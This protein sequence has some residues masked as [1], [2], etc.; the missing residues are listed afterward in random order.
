[1]L[2]DPRSEAMVNNF[3]GQWLQAR[4]MDTINIEART[5]LARDN[6]TEKELKQQIADALAGRG[7]RQGFNRPRPTNSVAGTNALGQ[8][9]LLAQARP[10][11]RGINLNNVGAGVFGKSDYDLSPEVRQ[12]MERETQM[13]FSTVMHEN[14]SVAELIESDYTFVNQKLAKFY[15]LTNLGITGTEMRRVTLP[16]DSPR[17]GL[18]TEGTFLAVTSNPDRTSPVKRGLFVLNN[19]LGSPPPPPPPNIPALEVAEKDFH[20]HEPTLREML[21][22]HRDRP[23][24]AACHSRLDPLG[25]AFENF[26]ALGMWRDGERSQKI[27]ASGHLITG[28]TFQS[29][30]ELKHILATNHRLEFYRCLATKLLTYATGRGLEYYDTETVDQIVQRME[31]ENGRFSA[32]LAGIIDSAPFQKERRQANPNLSN[33]PQDTVKSAANVSDKNQSTP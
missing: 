8:T 20:D 13:A 28:E 4:D 31:S 24:C 15:G 23:E 26:N 14:R 16:P 29:V 27:E 6:G 18:L 5:V 11:D 10:V 19:I 9:N 17:G 7:R 12:A 33:P 2:A 25:L 1:M 32:L 3:T 21:T 30:R 22:A